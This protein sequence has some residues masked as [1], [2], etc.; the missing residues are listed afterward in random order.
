[1]CSEGWND[2]EPNGT[3]ECGEDTVDGHAATGCNWSPVICDK[4]GA[5]P[6]DES[7]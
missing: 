1:M 7:C 2:G 3:C 5:A 4:C 6:C